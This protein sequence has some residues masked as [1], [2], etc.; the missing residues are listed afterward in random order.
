MSSFID[1]VRVF[2]RD[3]IKVDPF[4]YFCI[5]SCFYENALGN[6]EVSLCAFLE[7]D[8]LKTVCDELRKLGFEVST[9][10]YMGYNPVNITISWE[11]N[12]SE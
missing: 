1:E 12:D 2:T 8:M 11:E 6:A 5:E 10:R 7:D 9:Y 3:D 4:I